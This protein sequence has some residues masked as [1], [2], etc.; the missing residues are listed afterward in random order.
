MDNV[1][2]HKIG[3]N[4]EVYVEDV[5]IKIKEGHNHTNDLEDILQ[6]VRKYD[7]RLNPTKCSFRVQARKFMGFMLTR[8]GI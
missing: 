4:L 7:M 1:F 8:R 3:R 2:T 6:S 5:I